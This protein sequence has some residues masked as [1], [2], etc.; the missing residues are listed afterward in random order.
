MVLSPKPFD[1]PRKP[2]PPRPPAPAPPPKPSRVN[3]LTISDFIAQDDILVIDNNNFSLDP[4]PTDSS[5]TET[6][7][8]HI[9]DLKELLRAQLLK[10]QLLKENKDQKDRDRDNGHNKENIEN[11]PA[12]INTGSVLSPRMEHKKLGEVSVAKKRGPFAGGIFLDLLQ[13]SNSAFTATT[14]FEEGE[15]E[16]VKT[17]ENGEKI[18]EELDIEKMAS[19]ISPFR[20]SG[21]IVGVCAPPIQI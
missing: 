15:R 6:T 19:L 14:T 10:E 17:L 3:K 8:H 18:L 12:S 21:G 16:K 11:L 4:S 5:A 9:A 2:L 7:D 13:V 20:T 1:S